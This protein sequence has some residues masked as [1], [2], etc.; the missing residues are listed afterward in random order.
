MYW[1]DFLTAKERKSLE[2][3]EELSAKYADRKRELYQ[4]LK[5]RADG[6]IRSAKAKEEG[7]R[8]RK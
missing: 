3:A 8:N 1:R 7:S 5:A 6:R 4:K 2:R